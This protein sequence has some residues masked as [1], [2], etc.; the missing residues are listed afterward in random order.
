MNE[1]MKKAIDDLTAFINEIKERLD[2]GEREFQIRYMSLIHVFTRKTVGTAEFV[3]VQAVRQESDLATFEAKLK[4]FAIIANETIYLFR[5]CRSPVDQYIELP[6]GVK[7]FDEECDRINEHIR[8]AYILPA[9]EN[10]TPKAASGS[11]C[12][13]MARKKLFYNDELSPVFDP[14]RYIW[15]HWSDITKM[16]CGFLDLKEE[17]DSR[18]EPLIPTLSKKKGINI[19]VKRLIESGE[20]IIEPWEAELFNVIKNRNQT[21]YIEISGITEPIAVQPQKLIDN[22]MYRKMYSEIN[23]KDITRITSRNKVIYEK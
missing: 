15:F 9:W 11:E 14:G 16:L 7:D 18:I 10:V 13:D 5:F 23:C 21:L 4:P 6:E 3:Y 17:F 2:K 20:V 1:A 19:E 12:R 8:N 22:L